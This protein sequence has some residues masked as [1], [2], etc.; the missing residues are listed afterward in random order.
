[1]KTP[2]SLAS[3]G[4]SNSYRSLRKYLDY[5][6]CAA[7]SN[8]RALWRNGSASDSRSEGCVFKSRRGQSVYFFAFFPTFV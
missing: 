7:D 4:T 2:R 5:V 8:R 6:L 3:L 1:M